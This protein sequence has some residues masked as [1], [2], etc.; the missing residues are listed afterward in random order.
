MKLTITAKIR[1]LPT[2]EQTREIDACLHAYTAAATSI[3]KTEKTAPDNTKNIALHIRH[4]QRIRNQYGLKSQQA[5]SVLKTVAAAYKSIKTNKHKHAKAPEFKH[6]FYDAVRG[7]DYT[8][9]D[10]YI[11]LNT[12]EK[13]RAKI[14]YRADGPHKELLKTG[15]LG[16][17]K[18]FKRHNKYYMHIP[19]TIEVPDAPD[20]VDGQTM[21]VGVDRGI[22][23][24]VTCYDSNGETMFVSG[25]EVIEKR[26]QYKAKR[27]ELQKKGTPSAR[28]KLKAMGSRENRWMN[29]VN[30]CLSKALVSK[31]P[32][33]TIFVLEDLSNIRG[34]LVMSRRNDRYERVSWAYADLEA[35]LR[36]K[37]AR[38]GDR[39]ILV[40]P[41]YS[42]QECPVC[43]CV[44]KHNRNKHSHTFE[45]VECGYK[46]NDDRSAAMVLFGRGR[47]EVLAELEEHA[48]SK[49]GSSQ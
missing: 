45:C 26:K 43:G 32:A 6:A 41:A 20:Y 35:K 10:D 8:I 31:Y 47:D 38:V 13:K 2:R 27:A 25:K 18:V 37:A 28:R 21:I 15:K 4:Y 42:S 33:G 12:L 11:T 14:R 5:C 48:S 3:A 29:D 24:L 19:V 39:I 30:H 46:S 9:K 1:L 17:A 23:F 49:L 36:Y 44:D 7:R 22:R 34:A 40:D 16:T